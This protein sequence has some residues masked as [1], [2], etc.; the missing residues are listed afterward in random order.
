MGKKLLNG[1]VFIN[2]YVDFSWP[3]SFLVYPC[4]QAWERTSIPCLLP[5]GILYCIGCGTK[6]LTGALEIL[7]VATS[8]HLLQP[9]QLPVWYA[10]C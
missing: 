4:G 6:E 8:P 1:A 2:N 10:I 7:G 9:I 5:I 3:S